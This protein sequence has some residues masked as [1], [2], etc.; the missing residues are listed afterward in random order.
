MEPEVSLPH[1]QVPAICPYSEPHQSSPCFQSQFLKFHLNIILQLHSGLPSG[2]F[3]SSFP[4]KTLYTPL[5]SPIRATWP[6]HLILVSLITRIIFG[7]QYRS[8]SSSLCS[9][10]HSPV[11]SSLLPPNISPHPPIL[12]HPQPT[13]C[14]HF[15]CYLLPKLSGIS[16]SYFSDTKLRYS[17]IVCLPPFEAVC[18][19]W[20]L[21]GRG[22]GGCKLKY[23]IMGNFC[24]QNLMGA[25]WDWHYTGR[26]CV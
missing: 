16:D 4:T 26:R 25:K 20:G 15:L 10:L 24:S 6:S 12:K 21:G 3:P 9:F 1:L 8:L 22:N 19:R 7:E 11:S 14:L 5:F 23:C 2:L 13:L 18:R 17:T